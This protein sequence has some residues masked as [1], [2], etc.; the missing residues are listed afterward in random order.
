MNTIHYFFNTSTFDAYHDRVQITADE[1]AADFLV[2]G[3]KDVAIGQFTR[4]KG[5][6]RF[7]VGLDNVPVDTL[8][9]RQIPLYLPSEKT[10]KVLYESTANFTVY[11]IMRLLF[12]PSMGKRDTWEKSPRRCCDNY[13]ILVVGT[14]HIGS[15][16][17]K[18]L[19]PFFRVKSFDIK[20]D[21]P[22]RLQSLLCETD[23]LTVHIPLTDSNRGY[24]NRE[25]L[26]WLKDDACIVNTA[27][28]ALFDEDDLYDALQSSHRRAAFDVF[29]EEPYRGKLSTLSA[30][31]FT[32]TPHTA[33]TTREFIDE[34]F[35]DI[36]HAS[37]E[38]M[39]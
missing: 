28:G 3:A 27:R 20:N 37:R 32:M 35:H 22:D 23:V 6:Y 19:T 33:S 10:K 12:E 16:V 21:H 29:W 39:G 31:I 5:V 30:D 8:K 36:L 38:C 34:G 15:L 7:G 24:F 13:Q 17:C 18:K 2:M 26:E 25:K 4:L 1:S 11:S 14:G 9:K